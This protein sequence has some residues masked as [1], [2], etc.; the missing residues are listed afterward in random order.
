MQPAFTGHEKLKP[1]PEEKWNFVDKRSEGVKHR[2]ELWH[3]MRKRKQI[4]EDAR[5]M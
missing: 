1:K 5:Q 2:T 3:E 4:H